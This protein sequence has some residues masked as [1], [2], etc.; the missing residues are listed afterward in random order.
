MAGFH[1]AQFNIARA[2]A[3][4]DDPVMAGFV[5][6]L[7]AVNALAERTPA[8]VCLSR[9]ARRGVPRPAPVVRA[10]PTALNGAPT[11][12]EDL[13]PSPCSGRTGRAEWGDPADGLTPPAAGK[14]AAV[15]FETSGEWALLCLGKQEPIIEVDLRTVTQRRTGKIR[16]SPRGC[17]LNL[18]PMN[19]LVSFSSCRSEVSATASCHKSMGCSL[20]ANRRQ[21]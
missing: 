19:D 15:R 21:F 3:A 7:E 5:E 4:L 17:A 12:R 10:A 8:G 13:R 14:A 11:R 2:R 18:L 9:T 6:Q 16:G 20:P 1:L